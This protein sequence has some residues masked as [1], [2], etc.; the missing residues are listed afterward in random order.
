MFQK[1]KVTPFAK[2]PPEV[3]RVEKPLGVIGQKVNGNGST[4]NNVNNSCIHGIASPVTCAAITSM[5]NSSLFT[6]P[7][8]NFPHRL[9][10]NYSRSLYTYGD[11]TSLPSSPAANSNHSWDPKM[12]SAPTPIR[13]PPGLSQAHDPSQ[14]T[15]IAG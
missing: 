12:L 9:K 3:K 13:P 4:N 1:A 8:N 10:D 5:A 15:P 2:V 6:I 14:H 11:N 7:D